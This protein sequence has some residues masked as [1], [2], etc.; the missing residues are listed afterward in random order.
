MVTDT[1]G[2]V[3]PGGLDGKR[4]CV[5]CRRYGFDSLVGKIPWRRK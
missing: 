1:I 4:I 5:Q 2:L 3:F